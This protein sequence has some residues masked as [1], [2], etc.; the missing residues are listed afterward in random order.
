M[1]CA[2]RPDLALSDTYGQLDRALLLRLHTAG[3]PL[4]QAG[5]PL[6][7]ARYLLTA[8]PPDTGAKDDR[9]QRLRDELP[10]GYL[11]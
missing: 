10:R 8:D 3:V 4:G 11:P 5:M 9:Q 6:A 2:L 7:A 1:V